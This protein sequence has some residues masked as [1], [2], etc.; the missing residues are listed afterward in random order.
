[1][2]TDVV[3]PNPIEKTI[4]GLERKVDRLKG[5]VI[6]QTEELTKTSSAKSDLKTRVRELTLELDEAQKAKT[7]SDLDKV[8]AERRLGRKI[9]DLEAKLAVKAK[10]AKDRDLAVQKAN[11]AKAHLEDKDVEAAALKEQIETLKS[12]LAHNRSKFDLV[13]EKQRGELSEE[14]SKVEKLELRIHVLQ[15]EL[16][17]EKR[18]VTASKTAQKQADESVRKMKLALEENNKDS[19]KLA[20]R[21][22]RLEKNLRD[23]ERA[24]LR[25]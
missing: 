18:K 13:T 2:V 20:A 21:V 16:D 4:Y 22:A 23:M 8:D 17:A 5:S 14:R 11:R 25:T 19:D 24:T 12:E 3:M 6:S 9:E 10:E 1:M 15:T 7:K